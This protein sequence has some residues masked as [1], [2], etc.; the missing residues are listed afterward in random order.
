MKLF[1]RSLAAWTSAALLAGTAALPVQAAEDAA[2]NVIYAESACPDFDPVYEDTL[3]VSAPEHEP[4]TVVIVQHSPERENLL[5]Y[6]CAFVG[7][8]DTQYVFRMEPG[9]YTMY[10]TMDAVLQ[11][12]V[13]RTLTEDF[14][15]DNPDYFKFDKT[16]YCVDLIL[17]P[18][19]GDNGAVPFVPAMHTNVSDTLCETTMIAQFGRYSHLRG[20]Y[21]GDNET[22]LID[23][24]LT[25]TEYTSAMVGGSGDIPANAE[26]IAACDIDGDGALTLI[27]AIRILS[28]YTMRII[29]Q[30]PEW[31]DGRSDG[32]YQS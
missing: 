7:S 22:D 9:D 26:Q 11:S 20:D 2:P 16:V 21:N 28:F 1:M 30:T 14:T 5:L 13:T 4:F 27:D 31:P 6:D 10:L 18:V 29:G 25:L 23:A 19:S 32:R 24:I 15:I 8:E 17:Q 12:A 3:I